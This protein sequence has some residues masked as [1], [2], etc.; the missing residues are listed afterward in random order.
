MDLSF[1]S[2]IWKESVSCTTLDTKSFIKWDALSFDENTIFTYIEP[3]KTSHFKLHLISF[4][5]LRDGNGALRYQGARPL[6][7]NSIPISE[8]SPNNICCNTWDSEGPCI[9][10]TTVSFAHS[11]SWRATFYM[12]VILNPKLQILEWQD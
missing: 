11:T 6:F 8:P 5:S 10:A 12:I 2:Q 9:S 3:I 1:E 7:P 4:G